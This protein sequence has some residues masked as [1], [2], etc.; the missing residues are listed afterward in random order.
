MGTVFVAVAAPA[1][2]TVRRFR[3]L[4][5]R[6]AVKWQSAQAALDMLRRALTG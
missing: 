5:G 1:G 3:F 4:G 2:V 6:S